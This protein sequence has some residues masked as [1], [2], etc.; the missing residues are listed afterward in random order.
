MD[1]EMGLHRATDE[2]IK[3]TENVMKNTILQK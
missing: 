1:D 3:R 2:A